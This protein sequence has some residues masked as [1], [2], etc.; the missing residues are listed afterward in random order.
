[1]GRILVTLLLYKKKLLSNP[2]FFFSSYF[3]EN[4]LHYFQSLYA[5][6][7]HEKDWEGWVRFFLKGIISEGKENCARAEKLLRKQEMQKSER[8]MQN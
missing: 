2:L 1:V 3:K 5:I 6:S 4:R 8:R 7:S